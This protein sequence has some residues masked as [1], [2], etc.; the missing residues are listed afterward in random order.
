MLV[1]RSGRMI[2]YRALST[3]AASAAPQQ[4][5]RRR[6]SLD[7]VL[8]LPWPDWATMATAGVQIT[9]LVP[10]N[11]VVAEATHL[12]IEAEFDDAEQTAFLRT[13]VTGGAHLLSFGE[14]RQTLTASYERSIADATDIGS[15]Q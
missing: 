15:P 11:A 1:L 9:A 6:R 2:E 8:Q 13:L 4:T 12:Q 3:V 10:A 14:T 5:E 7:V